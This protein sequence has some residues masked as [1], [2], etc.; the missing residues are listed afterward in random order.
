MFWKHK[1]S[2]WI[3]LPKSKHTS[4]LL[5]I[6]LHFIDLHLFSRAFDKFSLNLKMKLTKQSF[7]ISYTIDDCLLKPK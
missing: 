3:K 4:V 5:D 7:D 2:T 1:L 6:C